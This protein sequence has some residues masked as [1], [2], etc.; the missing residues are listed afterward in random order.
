MKVKFI[1]AYP[2]SL[3]D[4]VDDLSNWSEHARSEFSKEFKGKLSKAQK[5]LLDKY[6]KVR[7]KKGNNWS[8]PFQVRF[9]RKQTLTVAMSTLDKTLKP[10]DAKVVKRVFKE[11][12]KVFAPIYEEDEHYVLQY[13]KDLEREWKPVSKKC[14]KAIEELYNVKW[15]KFSKFEVFLPFHGGKKQVTS[16][17]GFSTSGGNN[18]GLNAITIDV[19]R[20]EPS[21][22]LI[23]RNL[24]TMIHELTHAVYSSKKQGNMVRT[25]LI[26]EYGFSR[27][28][29]SVLEEAIN[30]SFA[31]GGFLTQ[32]LFELKSR[33]RVS[34]KS[35]TYY[36]VAR[37]SVRRLINNLA[38]DYYK[39]RAERDFWTDFLPLVV[40]KVSRKKKKN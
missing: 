4:F 23:A 15:G 7:K 28:R 27:P 40:K 34:R 12:H 11:F 19:Y 32:E 37:D 9:C 17:G 14:L 39:H 21:E 20:Y 35:D 22:R 33:F 18:I 1:A 25:L 30:D 24:A 5:K 6:V 3:F 31:P 38:K 29:A 13:K 36:D 10:S 2:V 26:K 16:K 8:S